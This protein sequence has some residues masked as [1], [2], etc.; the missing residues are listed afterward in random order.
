MIPK[1]HRIFFVILFYSQI[2][3]SC[4]PV[5]MHSKGELPSDE[6]VYLG[7]NALGPKMLEVQLNGME[8]PHPG[9]S[10]EILPGNHT[11]KVRYQVKFEDSNLVITN[12]A[13]FSDELSG[14]G[15]VRVGSCEIEFRA[16]RGDE[17]FVYV[18]PGSYSLL[19]GSKHPNISIKESG[20]NTPTLFESAC[21]EEVMRPTISSRS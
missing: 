4:G 17:L 10:L 20:F 13:V 5:V 3:V 11:L 9:R 14:I 16:E 12:D 15:F 1:T 2:L 21:D 7:F 6:L 19:G 8:N 18:T